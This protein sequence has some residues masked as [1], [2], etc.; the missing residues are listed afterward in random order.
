MLGQFDEFYRHVVRKFAV[1]IDRLG[2]AERPIHEIGRLERISLIAL[3][4]LRKF[5]LKR[6][7]RERILTS[8]YLDDAVVHAEMRGRQ[9]DAEKPSI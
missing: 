4:P 6:R 7:V 2:L 8:T 1:R 9:L 3:L 5:L